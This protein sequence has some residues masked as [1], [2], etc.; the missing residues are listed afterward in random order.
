MSHL[1]LKS[2]S[3]KNFATF[4]DQSIL[5]HDGLN[6]IIGETGSGKSLVLDALEL[7]LG[8]RAEKKLIRK[9]CDFSIVE[10]TFEPKE[11]KIAEFFN[12]IGHPFEEDVVIKR[13]I[14]KTESSKAY[15][16]FQQANVGL[17]GRISKEFIDLVGQ[18][19]NQ[20]LFNENYQIDL[21]DDFSGQVNH[22]SNFKLSFSKYQESKVQFEALNQKSN[23]TI[24]RLDYLNF[25]IN[26]LEELN[27]DPEEE[28]LLESKKS[29]YLSHENN[30]RIQEELTLLFDG[31]DNFE[32]I[33]NSLTKAEKLISNISGIDKKIQSSFLDAKETINDL[34]YSI[35]KSF[36]FEVSEEDLNTVIEKLDSYSKLKNKYNTD[37]NG[38]KEILANFIKEKDTLSNIESNL[39]KSKKDM[40]L[41][42]SRTLEYAQVIHNI[43]IEK[44][45]ALTDMLTKAVQ[46]LRMNGA[47][48][49]IDISK[50]EL[51]SNGITKLNL[52]AQTNPGEGFYKVKDIASGGELS[53]ILLAL[54]Q[55]LS[56]SECV[57]IFLFDEIDSGIGGE[58]AL[59][60]GKALKNVAKS[61]Q[62]ISITH[63]PQIA[64]FADKL[65]CVSKNVI[66][67]EDGQRTVSNIQEISG[68][69]IRE[70]IDKM[71]PLYN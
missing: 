53:R 36:D 57:S 60:I 19:E 30:Q 52:M 18:F 51:T 14:Y 11:K 23:D 10:A 7:I 29:K 50:K 63:L 61:S 42:L 64:S 40:E 26:E 33:I 71:T 46:K 45:H 3:L 17:L 55:V 15:V 2:L 35:S 38:L 66:T 21:L 56:S 12:E 58:T 1:I 70:Q 20:K 43:R 48:F 67:T 6:A 34:S 41:H 24:Q 22:F 28:E 13:I 5:F 39:S 16:N 44:S 65:V 25:Q 47:S 32:G 8:A 9:G 68:S 69:S 59:L 37:S 62:V 27:P 54:R 4:D 31:N 49:R